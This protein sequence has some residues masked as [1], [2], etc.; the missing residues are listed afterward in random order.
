M[1]ERS[2]NAWPSL[3][4]MVYDGWILR[5]SNGYTKRAN[6]INPLYE[7]RNELHQKIAECEHIFNEKGLDVV[8]KMTLDVNPRHLD[9]V[10]EGKGYSAESY[11]SVQLVELNKVRKP[12]MSNVIL[13]ESFTDEWMNDFCQLNN[14]E[15]NFKDTM[16]HMLKRIV[17][18]S[19]FI[20]LKLE[21]KTT[22]C[23][24][25]V[26]EGEYIGLFDI[27]TDIHFR[28]QG[29]GEEL[30]LHLIQW[31]KKKGAKHAYLQVV[32]D[33]LPALSL[34]SKMGFKEKYQYWYR[35]KRRE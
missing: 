11:T 30:L 28:R 13:D 34:Y 3:Q 15:E 17:H 31:G 18:K 7:S 10:L 14:I 24:L 2:I 1:E 6:S 27:I 19:C 26:L 29:F 20:S 5:F 12:S 25:G 23:G 22:A 32:L 35:I 33:N 16:N 8:Y 9:Q 4:T 21:Q